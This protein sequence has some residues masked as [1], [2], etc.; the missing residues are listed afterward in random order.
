MPRGRPALEGSEVGRSEG[1]GQRDGSRW[2]G[3]SIRKG[4]NWGG[5]AMPWE[6][7]E[8]CGGAPAPSLGESRF[9][10]GSHVTPLRGSGPAN[11]TRDRA[12]LLKSS[13][14]GTPVSHQELVGR[15]P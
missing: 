5:S 15:G 6:R 2:G 4:E 7:G 12:R 14:L 13:K 9:P 11:P 10:E 3:G 8:H 1:K